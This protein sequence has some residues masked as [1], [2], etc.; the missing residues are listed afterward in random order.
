[1]SDH[2][3]PQDVVIFIRKMRSLVPEDQQDST[4]AVKHEALGHIDEADDAVRGF[5]DAVGLEQI[6]RALLKSFALDEGEDTRPAAEQQLDLFPEDLRKLVSEINVARL[7]VPS[8]K[9]FMQFDPDHMTPDNMDEAANY[10]DVKAGQTSRR[11]GLVRRVA[12]ALRRR[13]RST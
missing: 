4:K 13:W 9:G 8:A 2:R 6:I 11:A 5:I 1:M 10:L 12:R 7:F 3:Y